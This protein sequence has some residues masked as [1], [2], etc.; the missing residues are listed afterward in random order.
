MTDPRTPAEALRWAADA[1]QEAAHDSEGATMRIE[2]D[3]CSPVY[4]GA[5]L[6]KPAQAEPVACGCDESIAL[7]AQV[8]WLTAERDEAHQAIDTITAEHSRVCAEFDVLEKERDDYKQA[9][10]AEAG[11]LDRFKLE[12][13]ALARKLASVRALCGEP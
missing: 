1:A 6:A 7:R 8:A 9:A 13:D 12:R 5:A 11:G 2:D 10:R 4:I 3:G